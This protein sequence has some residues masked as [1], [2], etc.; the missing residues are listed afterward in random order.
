MKKIIK[1]KNIRKSL[2]LSIIFIFIV[3]G[4]SFQVDADPAVVYVDDDY[5]VSTTG[6]NYDH[7][8]SIQNAINAVDPAGTV[9][10]YNG[11]YNEQVRFNK[12]VTLIGESQSGVIIDPNGAYFDGPGSGG[13]HIRSAVTFETDCSGSVLSYVTIQ[14]NFNSDYSENSGIEVI[15]GDIDNIVIK[16]VTVDHVN[17]HGFGTYHSAYTWPPPSGWIIENCSFSTTDEG[18]WFSGMRPENMDHITIQDCDVGPTNF[19]GIWLRNV[20]YGVVQRCHVF[21][22]LWGGIF[23]DNYCTNTID[24]LYNEVNNTNGAQDIGH[25]DI[26]FHGQFL[27]DPHGDNPATV[28]VSYNLLRDSYVGFSTCCDADITQRT[29][30]MNYNNVINHEKYGAANDAYGDM[31]APLNWWG[32]ASGPGGQGPGTGDNVSV[33]VIFYPWLDDAYPNGIPLD[34]IPEIS[35]V[36]TQPNPQGSNSYVNISCDV[37]DDV[38][39]DYVRVGITYPD[40]TFQNF[41]MYGNYY[42][43]TTYGQGGTYYYSIWAIDEFG[44]TNITDLYEFY[45]YDPTVAHI[46]DDYDIS[47]PGWQIDRFDII[48]D[49]IDHVSSDGIIYIMNGTYDEQLNISKTLTLEAEST[50]T[51]VQPLVAPQA[52]IYDVEIDASNVVVQGFTFDFNG[53][54]DTRGGQGIVVS[55]LNGPAATNVE[56]KNNVI[57]SGDG[58]GIGGTCIQ[59][60]KNADISNLI[61]QNNI[62]YADADGLGEGVYINPGPG[63]NIVI[64]NNEFYGNLFSGISIEA[65][66]VTCSN[67]II[68][69]DVTN[70]YY[71]VRF[72]ELTGGETFSDV[73]I[74]NNDISHV[75][76][77]IRVGT[78]TGVGSSLTAT[79]TYNDI[80]NCDIGIWLRYGSLN[81]IILE[82]IIANNN[83]YGIQLSSDSNGNTIYHNN[84]IS[85][86][87]NAFD[88]GTNTWDDGNPS[89]GN[90]WS[91]YAG[92]DS[93]GDGIGD[94]PYVIPGGSNQDLNPLIYQWGENRPFADFIYTKIQR[95][96]DGTP[97]YDRDGNVVNWSWN[98]GDGTTGYGMI[99]VHA[100]EHTGTYDVTLTVTDDD[101]YQRSI[102]KSIE[103]DGNVKPN[104]PLISGPLSGRAGRIYSFSFVSGDPDG[105]NVYYN[106]L[107]G[108]GAFEEWFGPYQ[109]DEITSVSHTWSKRGIYKIQARAKDS[110]G[111]VSDWSEI[112]F[113][114]SSIAT[115]FQTTQQSQ[116][117]QQTQQQ[118][119]QTQQQWQ[120]TQPT[121]S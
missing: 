27:P 67:N 16:Y 86:T 64:D 82:N 120:Q 55:D 92:A 105:D 45:I 70:G 62:F 48:Q 37:T 36:N 14:N 119:Q 101:G 103:A 114:V 88:E 33:D 63:T 50:S 34:D 13:Y 108:D 94:T 9:N 71:G 106:V 2:V 84:L 43:N 97:S 21:E 46:D 20:N 18:F 110:W 10:V 7:F 58:S 74:S 104:A 69:S 12:T 66:N 107:W 116:Q 113:I 44:E 6:W 54:D 60:G 91:D 98:F 52:G 35:N 51:I 31:N 56:I 79:I 95:K 80:N 39:V 118:Q 78:N 100:Y 8:D 73:V 89:G 23:I 24:I 99:N 57:Y 87:I 93:N 68:D 76:N 4:I 75:A 77:G 40:S 109:S 1:V 61:I 29:I 26:K 121:R 115:V 112:T 90:Y 81:N 25:G 59:T 102:T 85:N 22:C 32:D 19:D 53:I 28:T 111:T 41:T 65:H 117:Q 49:G 38:G 72:I 42:F 47:T 15:E 5:D 96:F 30:N 11:I 3:A 17:G 83:N